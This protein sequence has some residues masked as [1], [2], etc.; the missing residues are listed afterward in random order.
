MLFVI[1]KKINITFAEFEHAKLAL[2]NTQRPIL[3]VES[4]EYEFFV[5]HSIFDDIFNKTLL[6]NKIPDDKLQ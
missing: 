5:H 3:S 6:E 1:Q 4:S 2:C